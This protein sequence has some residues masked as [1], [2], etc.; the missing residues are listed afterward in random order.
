SRVQ[1]RRAC[2]P[3]GQGQPAA[4][5]LA[6]CGAG[7]GD[8]GG[9][10]F[11]QGM[12]GAPPAGGSRLAWSSWGLL[13]SPIAGKPAPTGTAQGF[14]LALS[15]WELACRRLGRKAS[16]TFNSPTAASFSLAPARA[17]HPSAG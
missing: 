3:A 4:L 8:G 6:G 2:P 10:A 14:R 16:P 13:C 11:R 7:A 17:A 5:A 1:R 15:L 9:S 12:G